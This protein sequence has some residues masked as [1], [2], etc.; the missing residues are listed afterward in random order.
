MATSEL[1]INVSNDKY[2]ARISTL[3]GYVNSLEGILQQYQAQRA[4]VGFHLDGRRG[5]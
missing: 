4:K 1:I 2:S 3:Q 5:R